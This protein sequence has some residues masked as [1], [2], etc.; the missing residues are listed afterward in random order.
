M[1]LLANGEMEPLGE[2]YTRYGSAV[3]SLLWRILAP[4][5]AEEA[6]DLCQEVFVTLFKTADRFE[7]DR[8][9]RPW[10]FGIAVR[11][12][13]SWQRKRLIRGALLM[14]YAKENK[15]S[16]PARPDAASATRYQIDR[17]MAKLPRAQREVLVLTVAQGMSGE[18]IAETLGVNLN[19]VWTR[20]RRARQSMRNQL[21]DTRSAVKTGVRR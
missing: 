8:N 7:R 4:G 15:T 17:A 18:Q 9:L 13:R 5:Q 3:R 14:R 21:G 6:E 20:L 16:G 10:L 1:E 12:A 2:L 19:T 11:K